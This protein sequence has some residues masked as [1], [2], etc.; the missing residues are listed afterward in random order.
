MAKGWRDRG[1]TLCTCSGHSTIADV[2]AKRCLLQKERE[3]D[4]ER[5]KTEQHEECV[6]LT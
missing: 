5:K 2:R 3:R 1:G 6:R 4:R